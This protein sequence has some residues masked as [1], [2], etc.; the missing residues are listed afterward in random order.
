MTCVTI[1]AVIPC[2]AIH[3]TC[4][5]LPIFTYVRRMALQKALRMWHR[6]LMTGEA[7][8]RV[9][10]TS[11]TLVI[12]F[13]RNHTMCLYDGSIVRNQLAM[14]GLAETLFVTGTTGSCIAHTVRLSPIATVC[15]I[16]A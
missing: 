5:Q 6:R 3:T 10:V 13:A 16:K 4:F 7:E 14:T 11:V 15:R 12:R 2:M 9:S 8:I 1:G